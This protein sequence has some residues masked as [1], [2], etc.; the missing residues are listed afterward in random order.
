MNTVTK[1]IGTRTGIGKNMKKE[2]LKIV[3]ATL[4]GLTLLG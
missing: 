3:A 2:F 4:I 1:F